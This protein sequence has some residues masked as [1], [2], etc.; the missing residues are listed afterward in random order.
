[1]SPFLSETEKSLRNITLKTDAIKLCPRRLSSKTTE[2]LAMESKLAK[3]RAEKQRLKEKEERDEKVREWA[4]LAPLRRR[5][6]GT[7]NTQT[8]PQEENQP[9]TLEDTTEEVNHSSSLMIYRIFT[10]TSFR[11]RSIYPRSP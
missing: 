1:M 9:E 6:F 4:T 11:S 5:L 3:Y 2:L 7:G 8:T 10:Q